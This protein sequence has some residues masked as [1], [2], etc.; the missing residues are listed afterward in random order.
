MLGGSH[1]CVRTAGSV[2]WGRLRE[3]P[4]FSIFIYFFPFQELPQ[5]SD[6]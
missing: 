1:L 6:F 2:S 5:F 4:W 3:P